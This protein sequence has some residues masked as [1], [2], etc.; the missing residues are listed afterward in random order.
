MSDF[1][2]LMGGGGV[3]VISFIF[4]PNDCWVSNKTFYNVYFYAMYK[5]I[6]M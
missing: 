1:Q 4:I 2:S 5:K 3:L 6:Y